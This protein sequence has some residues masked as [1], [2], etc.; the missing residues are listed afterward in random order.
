MDTETELRLRSL[1]DDAGAP[2]ARSGPWRVVIGSSERQVCLG[3]MDRR[4]TCR[5]REFVEEAIVTLDLLS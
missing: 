5:V 1:A 4:D 2:E 3:R